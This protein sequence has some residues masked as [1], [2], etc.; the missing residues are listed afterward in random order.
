MNRIRNI[1]AVALGLTLAVGAAGMASAQTT[2]AAKD[3]TPSATKEQAQEKLD[4]D[5][6]TLKD[7]VQDGI[8]ASEANI[9]ALKRLQDNDKGAT[10]QHEKDIE[11]KL[12][13]M[14]D[15]LKGDLDKIDKATQ[16]DWANVHAAVTT[17][18]NSMTQE[19]KVATNVTHVPQTTGAANK[20]PEPKAQPK[21]Q[22]TKP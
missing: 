11:K 13:D 15:T 18:L 1:A 2:G 7:K 8:G 22:P 12:S 17:H 20:Q 6:V 10:K 19:L 4:R 5:K 9:D 21:E 3:P 16:T 14:R